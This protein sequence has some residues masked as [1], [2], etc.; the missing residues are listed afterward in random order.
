[1]DMKTL[2]LGAIK[3][4]I[5]SIKSE[6]RESAKKA[7][8]GKNVTALKIREAIHNFFEDDNEKDDDDESYNRKR[9]KNED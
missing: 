4:F 1:M 2:L 7:M 9:K 8:I 5:E 6:K 3:R